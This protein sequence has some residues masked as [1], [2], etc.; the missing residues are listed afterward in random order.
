VLANGMGLKLGQLLLAYSPS[1]CSVFA[2][3]FLVDRRRL[4]K[5]ILWVGWR[6]CLLNGRLTWLE[7]WASSG[8]VSQLLCLSFKVMA[9][10]SLELP[11]FQ[12]SGTSKKFP[13]PHPHTCCCRFLFILQALWPSCLSPHLILTPYFIPLPLSHH[14]SSWGLLLLFYFPF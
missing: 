6:Q 10:D 12:I 4:G 11:T 7:E 14:V 5:Q 8:S 1:L 3:A 13:P 2:P 9:T